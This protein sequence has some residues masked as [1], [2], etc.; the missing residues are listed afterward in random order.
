MTGN[1]ETATKL[2]HTLAFLVQLLYNN[3]ID[4]WFI[5]YG[6]LL[7][8]T[9][10]NSCIEND[11]DIDIIIDI[12]YYN[13]VLNIFKSN[14]IKIELEK[15]HILK[16]ISTNTFASAD[17]YFSNYDSTTHNFNDVWNNVVWT[18]CKDDK[19]NFIQK[20]WNELL[21]NIPLN[22]EEKLIKRYGNDWK[23]P[24]NYKGVHT[25]EL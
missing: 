17:F 19:H 5:S 18:C 16:T 14:N 25:L 3:N 24:K 9:R 10:N 7:G 21:L 22:Y 11:D 12:K 4:N 8:I 15:K 23:T 6:T 13:L 2:N 20:E 1:K